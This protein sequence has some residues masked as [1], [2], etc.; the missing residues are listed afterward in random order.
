MLIIGAI[1]QPLV[2]SIRHD[3]LITRQ[4]TRTLAKHWI[5]THIPAEA[6]IAV[7]W[8][9]HGP[10]LSTPE[11]VM[12]YSHKVYHVYVV[13]GTGLS[14]Q[15]VVWYREQGFDYLVTSS[16]IY[17]LRLVY[18]EWDAERRIFYTL[19]DQDLRLVQEFRPHRDQIEPPFVFDEIYG[20]IVSLW[21]RERPG[22]TIRIYALD[23]QASK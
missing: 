4:D 8:E 15:P 11:K 1:A 9:T 22:P 17:D 18:E 3:V 14:E 20:P 23:S 21:Q 5:E 2:K 10:P 13:G 7:D 19:L 12:P 16:F 6:K